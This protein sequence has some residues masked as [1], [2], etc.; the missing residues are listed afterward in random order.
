[1]SQIKVAFSTSFK[2]ALR[3]LI[4]KHP[5]KQKKFEERLTLFIEDPYHLKLETHKLKGRLQ[6]TLPL[7]LNMISGLFFI[8]KIAIQ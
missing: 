3:S 2:K 7:P 4:K 1:M 8:L 5:A 6:D